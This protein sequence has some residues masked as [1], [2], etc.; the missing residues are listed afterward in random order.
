MSVLSRCCAQTLKKLPGLR[1]DHLALTLCTLLLV[2]LTQPPA[3]VQ[4]GLP[5]VV[6]PSGRVVAWH[7]TITYHIDQGPLGALN[8]AEASA[9]VQELFQRWQAVPSASLKIQM[10]GAMPLDVTA[11]NYTGYRNA[12]TDSYHPIIFDTDGSITDAIL[13]QGASDFTAGFASPLWTISADAIADGKIIDATAVLNGKFLDGSPGAL[14]LFKGAMLHEFGHFLGLGHSQLNVGAALD[15]EGYVSDNEAVPIMFPIW[16]GPH[17]GGLELTVDDQTQLARQYPNPAAEAS[18]GT[19]RG[20]V[21][22]PDGGTQFQGANVVARRID[23]PTRVAV[24]AVSGFLY[25]GTGA[26]AISGT[27]D[28]S[29]QGYY[30]ITGLPPGNYTVEVEPVHPNFIGGS[31]VGPL[32][33]PVDLPGPPEYY[34]GANESAS[35]SP[36]D[37][38]IITVAAGSATNYVNIVLNQSAGAKI[39]EAEANDSREQAQRIV[40][41]AAVSGSA[42]VVDAGTI[43]ATTGERLH[44][45]YSFDANADDVVTFDL[46]WNTPSAQFTLDVYD[47]GG[48]RIARALPCAYSAGCVASRQIGPLQL[49]SSGKYYVAVGAVSG[50]STYTLQIGSKRPAWHEN[51]TAITTVNAASFQPD[52]LLAPETIVSAF[53]TALAPVT[54]SATTQPLP[55][56]LAGVTVL[57]NGVPAPVFFVSPFQ[58]NY[59]IPAGTAA[60]A[61]SVVVTNESGMVSRGTVN[62][63]GVAP[64]FFTANATGSG[65]PAGYVTRSSPGSLLPSNEPLARY[66]AQAQRFVS[67][68]LAR[69]AGDEV[70]LILFGTGIRRAPEVDGSAAN[71]VAESVQAAVGGVPA[72]VVYAGPAPGYSGLDQVNIRIPAEAAA[73]LTVPVVVQVGDGHGGLMQANALTIG[74][75]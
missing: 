2:S 69:P 64:A 65:V 27:S 28:P 66:D 56:N 21:L 72:K 45:F 47:G 11:E 46:N 39:N 75:K 67:V 40:T 32:D 37:A 25:K 48:A 50:A 61:A 44:D 62:V 24:S 70:Y 18:Y 60:G 42:A 16:L 29:Y 31:R 30:E 15:R 17:P 55:T 58:V 52:A 8:N 73:G 22:M 38:T 54:R 59:L 35:D 4:A 63:A 68:E 53:G 74:L 49:K 57:V 5:L 13:G 51:A 19:I 6:T 20:Y 71:G 36:S 41:P 43:D 33:P 23:A 26:G 3:P 34:S 10:S 7:S 9:L 12:V 1:K 14:E